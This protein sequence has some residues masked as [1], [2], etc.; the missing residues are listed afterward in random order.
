MHFIYCHADE[1]NER[2][3]FFKE[4]L[5]GAAYEEGKVNVL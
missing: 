3:Q 5:P 4:H 2:I 1:L